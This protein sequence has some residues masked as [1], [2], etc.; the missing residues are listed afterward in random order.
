VK[1]LALVA[2]VAVLTFAVVV[3]GS[4]TWLSWR[5]YKDRP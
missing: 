3:A 1:T 2:A 4:V 5:A